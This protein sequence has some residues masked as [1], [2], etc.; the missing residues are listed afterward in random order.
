MIWGKMN[1]NIL[2][3]FE[4]TSARNPNGTCFLHVRGRKWERMSWGDVRGTVERLS[5]ALAAMGVKKGGRIGIYSSTRLEWTLADLAILACGAVTVPIYHT[6]PEERVEHIIKDSGIDL[7]IV[8]NAKLKT[9][10]DRIS[11]RTSKKLN[12]V[13]IDS[14]GT[15]SFWTLAEG[16]A[17]TEDLAQLIGDIGPGDIA[18]IIYT[19]GTTGVPKGVVLTHGNILAE[20]EATS[21]LFKFRQ[22]ETGFMCLPLSHVLGRLMEF[23][24]LALGYQLAFLESVEKFADNCREVSPDFI[25]GVPRMLEKM[26]ER[27]MKGVEGASKFKKRMFDRA[28]KIGREAGQLEQKHKPVPVLLRLKRSLADMFVFRT[29]RRKLGGRLR[30]FISG[31]APLAGELARFFQAIGLLV[32][33]GYGLTE[34]VAAATVNRL[35]DYHFGTVGKP[36]PG[37]EIT[38]AAD[39]EVLVRGP[40]V[41]REYL[42]MPEETRAAKTPDGWFRTG[43]IGALSRDGFLRITDRKKDIIVTAGGEN[44]AP[45]MI[46]MMLMESPFIN[47][48]MVYGD[49]KKYLVALVTLNPEAVSEYARKNGINQDLLS[50]S[51]HPRVRELISSIIEEKNLRLAKHETIKRFAILKHDLSMDEGELTPTLKIRRRFTSEKYKDIIESLYRE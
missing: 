43:D 38:L 12:A 41:F 28:M 35:D 18:S 11:A 16:T 23:H 10:L 51:Q 26:H 8:E 9:A 5:S 31:G 37:V 42:N 1:R 48:C 32:M 45:Q 7:V 13:V 29:V 4:G 49:R 46:E 15:N 33:E 21:G 14:G 2:Q 27:L 6:V 44:V 34:T 3:L 40:T 22:N 24:H 47:Y 50:V 17:N 36:V 25:V 39:G 20:V 30:L 19:S